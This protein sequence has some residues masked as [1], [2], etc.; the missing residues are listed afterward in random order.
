MRKIK[1]ERPN[2]HRGKRIIGHCGRFT[3]LAAHCVAMPRLRSSRPP[4]ASPDQPRRLLSFILMGN[5]SLAREEIT[6]AQADV[7]PPRRTANHGNRR[8]SCRGEP[9]VKPLEAAKNCS[10]LRT[11][12]REC[13]PWSSVALRPSGTD[14]GSTA[15]RWLDTS[16]SKLGPVSSGWRG[17]FL[18]GAGA[19][20]YSCE[21]GAL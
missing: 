3:Q 16:D 20:C 8:G 15:L 14:C 4:D 5:A 21:W 11:S 7:A 9:K 13:V 1:A 19:S 17:F 6:T 12:T 18:S 2:P 10:P